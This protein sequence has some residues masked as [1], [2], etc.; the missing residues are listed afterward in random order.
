M[1]LLVN[2]NNPEHQTNVFLQQ[3]CDK[4]PEINGQVVFAESRD[5]N[6]KVS[7]FSGI[8]YAL[9]NRDDSALLIVTV[10]PLNGLIAKQP[11]ISHL[12]AQAKTMY[13]QIPFSEEALLNAFNVAETLPGNPAALAIFSGKKCNSDLSSIR[14]GISNDG[15]REN[16]ENRKCAATE[17]RKAFGFIGTDDEVIEQ[18]LKSP[19]ATDI[20]QHGK[21]FPGVF[22]DIE[23]TLIR[24]GLIDVTVR[25][26]LDAQEELG[27]IINLWTGAKISDY[28]KTL[29]EAGIVWPLLPKSAFAGAEVET[30]MDDDPVCLHDSYG[31]T[32]HHIINAQ[33]LF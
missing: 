12:L 25:R 4:H 17:A 27:E 7:S 24:G 19:G 5:S 6:G 1:K 13:V 10:M 3:F 23:G 14:H 26:W 30:A 32:C 28:T 18:L 2:P 16:P 33:V 31:V 11:K 29:L 9:E 22:C 21:Y 8:E 15:R 20:D